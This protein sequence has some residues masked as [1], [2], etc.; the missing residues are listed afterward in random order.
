MFIIIKSK[1]QKDKEH[2]LAAGVFFVCDSGVGAEAAVHIH[3]I[4]IVEGGHRGQAYCTLTPQLSELL[5]KLAY[6]GCSLH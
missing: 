2:L 5:N 3:Y 6:S 4:T 1:L